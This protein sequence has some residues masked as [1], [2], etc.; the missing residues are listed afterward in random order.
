MP[1]TPLN[2]IIGNLCLSF[3]NS[4]FL[5]FN[6]SS[7]FFL[8]K[9]LDVRSIPMIRRVDNRDTKETLNDLHCSFTNDF[10]R[11]LNGHGIISMEGCEGFIKDYYFI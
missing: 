3:G 9:E 7:S 4:H 5:S 6:L 8:S 10:T 1:F 2:Y 11:V